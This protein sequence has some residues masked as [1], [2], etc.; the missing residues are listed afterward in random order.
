MAGTGIEQRMAI[1]RSAA[2]QQIVKPFRTHGWEADITSANENGEYLVIT[3][4]KGAVARRVAL[5]YT[6]ATDNA[7]YKTLDTAVDR[8]FTNGALYMPES[9]VTVHILP[10]FMR[11][12][13]RGS[14]AA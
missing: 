1:L 11:R 7:V 10:P 5:L 6:S 4:A 12:P 14:R 13:L 2:D 3:A 9:F 8:T